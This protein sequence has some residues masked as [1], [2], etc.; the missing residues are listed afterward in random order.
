MARMGIASSAF[1]FPS[2]ECEPGRPQHLRASGRGRRTETWTPSSVRRGLSPRRTTAGDPRARQSF[3]QLPVVLP[4]GGFVSRPAAESPGWSVRLRLSPPLPVSCANASPAIAF[5]SPPA[6]PVSALLVLGSGRA[7]ASSRNVS[8]VAPAVWPARPG[9]CGTGYAARG[10]G[11]RFRWEDASD[12][13]R[14]RSCSGAGRPCLRRAGCPPGT[15]PG[16][17]RP[18]QVWPRSSA[19]P[20]VLR[21]RAGGKA[22][23]R[24]VVTRRREHRDHL[25]P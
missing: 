13:P 4:G 24:K 10:Q 20:R 7:S 17:R 3:D 8:P 5:A 19:G 9:G 1:F 12:G 14:C 25:G 18:S 6:E 16:A 11:P 22:R 2:G 21:G 15:R 23:S